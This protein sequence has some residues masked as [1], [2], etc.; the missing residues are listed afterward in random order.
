MSDQADEREPEPSTH[1]P[2][3][4]ADEVLAT[5]PKRQLSVRWWWLISLFAVCV[6]P[7]GITWW[8]LNY[9]VKA[10]QGAVEGREGERCQTRLKSLWQGLSLYAEQNDGRLPPAA[11][12]VDASWPMMPKQKPNDPNSKPL[13][14]IEESESVFR[15]PS[16]SKKRTG[17]YG[18]AFSIALDGAATKSME[19]YDSMPLVF[20]SI[21]MGRNAVSGLDTLP[22]PPRHRMSRFNNVVLGNGSVKAVALGDKP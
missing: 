5:R 2:H 10:L 4:A 19:G 22:K 14:P 15:C 8:T 7:L 9:G 3:T 16:I 6:F 11:L 20:D 12:W 21:L 1:D 13:D 17:E 18:L